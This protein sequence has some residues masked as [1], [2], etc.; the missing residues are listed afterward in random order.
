VRKYWESISE[1][2]SLFLSAE[3][4][5]AWTKEPVVKLVNNR[6]AKFNLVFPACKSPTGSKG[7][8]GGFEGWGLSI[9]CDEQHEYA[10]YKFL[11]YS[12]GDDYFYQVFKK[13]N[14]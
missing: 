12:L 8:L 4:N 14:Y 9:D 11:N 7:C 2:T 1:L 13:M 3:I 5:R 6:N 10:S